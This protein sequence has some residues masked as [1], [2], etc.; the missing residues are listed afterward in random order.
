MVSCGADA[1]A[2]WPGLGWAELGAGEVEV[3]ELRAD[4]LIGGGLLGRVG[5]ADGRPVSNTAEPSE[6]SEVLRTGP[7]LPDAIAPTAHT[8]SSS[9]TTTPSTAAT[10]RRRYTDG[11]YGPCGSDTQRP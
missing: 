6:P 4:A 3:D 9:T 11:E 5:G 1:A 8:P 2:G 7:L 10:R